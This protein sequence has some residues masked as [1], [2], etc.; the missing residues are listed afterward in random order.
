[1]DAT[2]GAGIEALFVRPSTLKPLSTSALATVIRNVIFRAEPVVKPK[3]HDVRKI[4]AILA[5]LQTPSLERI[6]ELGQWKSCVSF[7]RRYLAHDI[8][9]SDPVAMGFFQILP[10]RAQQ[11]MCR[12][13]RGS[14]RWVEHEDAPG[15]APGHLL[16]SDSFGYHL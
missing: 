2:P 8:P 7:V 11:A 4:A 3:A 13:R 15:P 9:D 10:V 12:T 16:H 5:F 14:G 1:M 6:R